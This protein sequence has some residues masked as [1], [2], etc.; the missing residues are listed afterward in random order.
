MGSLGLEL[1]TE[2]KF[3]KSLPVFGTS[4]PHNPIPR[5]ERLR[6]HLGFR[7]SGFGF[8]V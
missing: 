8:R 5:L 7:V 3:L 6:L 1:G 2:C 4:Q